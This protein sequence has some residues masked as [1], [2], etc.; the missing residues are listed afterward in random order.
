VNDIY[1]GKDR[2]TAVAQGSETDQCIKH[3]EDTEVSPR[4]SGCKD[5]QVEEVTENSYTCKI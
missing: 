5:K 1:V 2:S 3:Q 4:T